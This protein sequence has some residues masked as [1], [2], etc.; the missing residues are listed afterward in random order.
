MKKRTSDYK[1]HT[2]RVVSFSLFIM[3]V[4][5]RPRV[6]SSASNC[7]SPT[8][9]KHVPKPEPPPP[10]PPR[11]DDSDSDSTTDD[12]QRPRGLTGLRN[13]GN[14]C[15]MNAALQALSNWSVLRCGVST[16]LL[17]RGLFHSF[18]WC[19]TALP[20]HTTP[21]RTFKKFVNI[22]PKLLEIILINVFYVLNIIPLSS[23][24]PHLNSD[25][26]LVE[27]EY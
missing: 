2:T 16:C 10:P 5:Q 7:C 6:H 15:Y 3:R 24:W 25:V 27:G 9:T 21:L 13:I 18:E 20:V 14:T 17:Q 22:H 19:T 11:A 26:G 8:T 1:S 23:T 12:T 4:L